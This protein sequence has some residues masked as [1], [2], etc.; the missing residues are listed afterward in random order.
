MYIRILTLLLFFQSFSAC[1]EAQ[2]S[3]LTSAAGISFPTNNSCQGSANA[4]PMVT[5]VI[6]QSTDGGH[7]WEDISAGLPEKLNVF[8][9]FTFNGQVYLI[10]GKG[11]Y[12]NNP[13]PLTSAWEKKDFS[14]GETS[15]MFQ[16]R[17]GPYVSSYYNGFYQEIAGSGVWMPMHNSLKDKTIRTVLETPDGAIL[18]GCESGMYKSVDKGSSWKQVMKDSYVNNLVATGNVIICGAETGLLRSSDGGENWEAVLTEDGGAYLG[19]VIEGGVASITEGK[20]TWQE[21]RTADKPNRLRAS[22]DNGKTWQRID[23]TLPK[24]LHIYDIKQAGKYLYSSCDTGIYR[25]ADRGKSW[26]LVRK[27][28]DNKRIVVLAVC[29]D[30]VYAVPVQGC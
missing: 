30:V 26:E 22:F 21:A 10:G 19:T 18:V 23:E 5:D 15:D 27:L 16:G 29:G 14:E 13:A 25:S 12:H 11:I 9:T 17:Y 2:D 7:T 8:R 3:L 28:E 4:A 1:Q 24:H 20:L 6:Y